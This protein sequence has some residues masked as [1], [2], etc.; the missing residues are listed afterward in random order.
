MNKTNSQSVLPRTLGTGGDGNYNMGR[1]SNPGMDCIVGRVK[2]E[3]DLPVRNRLL[4]EGL[5]LQND[6]VA[7]I[8]LYN[9]VI[10]WAMK[11]NIEVA[12]RSDN[13]LDWTLTKVN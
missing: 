6:T 4:T 2:T 5:Q 9:P 3:T 8:P 7:H 10:P 12:H 13:R 11:K 1:F